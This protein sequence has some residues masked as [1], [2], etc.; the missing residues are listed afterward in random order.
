MRKSILTLILAS[1]CT[2]GFSQVSFNAKAGLNLSS[3]MGSDSEGSKI[4]PGV[5]LGVGME[6]QFS[7]LFS[8]QPSL[9]FSQKGAK[10]SET[11]TE[12]GITASAKVTL[13]QLYLELPVNAQLR[14]KVG[15]NTNFIMATGPYFAYGVGGKAKVSAYASIGGDSGKAKAKIDTFS[16]SGMDLNRFDMGWNLGLG[17]EFDRFLVG[18]DSQFGFVDLVEYSSTRNMNFGLTL[19]YKF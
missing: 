19:G 16:E 12:S 15:N 11:V 3:H 5:R 10:G 14:F 8:I 4:K 6:Y 9:F 2:A 13:D 7:E 17:L 1:A 18:V